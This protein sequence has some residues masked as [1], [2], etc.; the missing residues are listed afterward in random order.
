MKKLLVVILLLSLIIVFILGYLGFIPGLSAVFGSNQPKKLGITYTQKDKKSADEKLGVKYSQLSAE[1]KEKGLVLKGSH[2]VD[3][4]LTS[5]ELTALA[6]TRQKQFALFPFKK[7]QIRVNPDGTV[8]GSGILE[9]NTALNFLQTLEVPLGEVNKAIDKFKI[10]RGELPVYLK[11]SGEVVNN[12]SNLAVKSAEIARIP[13]P[14]AL[15]SQ[16][17]P[18]LNSLVED[19]VSK[20]QPNYEI[21]SLKVESGQVHFVGSSPDE[22][23]AR[24]K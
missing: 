19:I 16:Y 3:K 15:V 4:S 22:E 20:R 14:Q 17:G 13:I 6:D 23:W 2:P 9:F 8:E 7:V 1:E 10:L 5:Q 24:G 12:I 11:V 21:R 18:S